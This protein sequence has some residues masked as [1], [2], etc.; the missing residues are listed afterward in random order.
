MDV[1]HV[2]VLL[3]DDHLMVREGLEQL[4]SGFAGVEVVGAAASGEEA[5]EL[6]RKLDPDVVLMDLSMPGMGGIRATRR[7][8]ADRPAIRVVV[9]SS[10]G[11]SA[12]VLEAIDAGA[13]GFL[14]KDAD[15]EELARAVRAASRG[16][17]PLDPR[18]ARAILGRGHDD[19]L[20]GMTAREREVLQLVSV[21]HPNKVIAMRL[22]ISEATVKAH[23]TRIYRQLG[24]ADRTQAAILARRR[25]GADDHLLQPDAGDA[26][27]TGVSAR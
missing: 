22:G 18:A 17:A 12:S 27:S 20:D 13:T 25:P 5:V 7:I 9:L 19:P 16:E 6:A 15:G 3:C 4:L 8:R 26:P 24:V 1:D 2:R 11:E 23:L 14:L 21:G 10:F